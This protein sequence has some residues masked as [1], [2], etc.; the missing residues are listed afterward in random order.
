VDSLFS[1]EPDLIS[2]TDFLLQRCP[3]NGRNGKWRMAR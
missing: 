3:T 1:L 2:D